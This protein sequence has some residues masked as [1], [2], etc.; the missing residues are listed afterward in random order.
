V[1]LEHVLISLS[2]LLILATIASKVSSSLGVPSLVLFIVVGALAGSEG[3]GNIEFWDPPLAQHIGTIALAFIL[4]SGGLDTS[5]E[6]IKPVLLHGLALSTLGVVI[7]AVAVALFTS[8]VLNLTLLEG[9]LLGSVVS[10]TDA[11]AE[12]SAP[13]FR[14]FLPDSARPHHSS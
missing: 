9:L 10:S 7:T 6:S 11:A 2:L 8:L 13:G 1:P 14:S 3:P 5:W 12:V 4:F